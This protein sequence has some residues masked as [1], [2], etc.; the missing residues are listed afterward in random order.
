[1]LHLFVLVKWQWFRVVGVWGM[2]CVLAGCGVKVQE[3][4]GVVTVEMERSY[5]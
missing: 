5:G 4:S 3:M 1:M 2:G